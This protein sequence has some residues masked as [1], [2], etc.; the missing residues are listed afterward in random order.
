VFQAKREIADMEDLK[1]Q[2]YMLLMNMLPEHVADHFLNRPPDSDDLYSKSYDQSSVIFASIPG[3]SKYFQQS[4][5]IDGQGLEC[6]RMLNEIIS[7]IDELLNQERFHCIE[8]IKT[9]GATYMA[10]AGLR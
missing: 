4:E 5:E 10:C 1:K 6:L 2:T 7:S 3:F 8:K 9:I